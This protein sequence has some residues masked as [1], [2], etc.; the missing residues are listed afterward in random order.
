MIKVAV[1]DD[2]P[3]TRRLLVRGLG[4][5]SD[6]QV[7]G[8]AADPY[9]A[10][11]LILKVHPDVLTLD[12][13]MPKMD[14]MSFLKALVAH[15]PIPVVIVSG[16]ALADPTLAT[17]LV[18]AGAAAVIAKPVN[19]S[20]SDMFFRKLCDA[21]KSAVEPAPVPGKEGGTASRQIIAVGAS[22]GGT[23]ALEV[24]MAGMPADSPGVVIVQHLP[25]SF[26]QA[27]VDRLNAASPMEVRA[28]RAGELVTPGVALVAPGAIHLAIEKRGGHWYTALLDGPPVH[29]Q[30]PAVDV[31]FESVARSAGPQAIGVLLTGMGADGAAGMLKIRQAGGVTFSEHPSTCVVWGMP[32]AAVE[33]DAVDA[34]I[35]LPEMAAEV[36]RAAQLRETIGR[37]RGGAAPSAVAS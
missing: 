17:R 30:R 13:T 23:K 8:E 3:S 26:T 20:E 11:E 16:R 21:L 34:Q 4:N 28:A 15:Y 12:L 36:Y 25:A 22:T 9:E 29:H 1:I 19:A 27:F 24:M 14:G 31:L 37:R 5:C 6:L 2:S 35:P 18:E 33:L 10:R 32:R 7:V